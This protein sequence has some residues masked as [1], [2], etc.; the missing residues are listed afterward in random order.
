MSD[1][2]KWSA[3]TISASVHTFQLEGSQKALEDGHVKLILPMRIRCENVQC[4]SR[5]NFSEA[6]HE[7]CN[8]P[9]SGAAARHLMLDGGVVTCGT[10]SLSRR[11]HP[12]RSQVRSC[13]PLLCPL[14]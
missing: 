6:L 14:P 8:A 5:A 10:L 1:S 4:A 7:H 11:A 3:L 2:A 13:T 9:L 12:A